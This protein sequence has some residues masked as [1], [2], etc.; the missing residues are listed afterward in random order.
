MED[1]DTLLD[2]LEKLLHR[3]KEVIISS[4][5]DEKSS[6][7]LF[8]TVEDK[9]LILSKLSQFTKEEALERKDRLER[10]DSLIQ[11]NKE[12]MLQNLKFIEDIFE[13][14]FETNKTYSPTGSVKPP[15]EGFINKKV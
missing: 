4:L 11:M 13:A 7:E 1:L 6:Q 10:I 5:K 14:I 9:M 2:S 8:Q 15:S 12:L 3:E